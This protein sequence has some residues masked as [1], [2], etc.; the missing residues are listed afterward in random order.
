MAS[1]WSVWKR[2]QAGSNKYSI[3]K[4][5]KGI[6]VVKGLTKKANVLVVSHPHFMSGKTSKARRYGTRIIEE[7]TF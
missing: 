2:E 4:E 1:A 3:G 7:R 5:S 6:I